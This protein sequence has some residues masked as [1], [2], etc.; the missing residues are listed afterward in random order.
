MKIISWNVNGIRACYKKGFAQYLESEA[1]D[2]LCLQESKA[3][4]ESLDDSILNIPNYHSYWH[5]AQRKGYS[6][7][8]IYSKEKPLNVT[9]GFGPEKFDSEGRVISAEY[10]DYIVFSVYFPNGQQGP[11]RLAYKLEFYNEF[12]NYCQALRET[13]KELI[14]CGDYNT[15][16]TEIDLANPK[17]NINTS[18]FM[19]IEREWLD[20]IIKLGYIDTFRLYNHHPDEYSWWS[21]RTAARDRNVGWR[22]DYVFIT[23]GLQEKLASGFIQQHVL[24]SDHCP[25]GIT[26]N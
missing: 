10:K 3:H 4:V 25:V 17:E 22:I 9:Y 13:G 6:G 1:P 19:P 23:P 16:H 18:G 2:V 5:S 20:H 11:E 24:G 26:L 14:I 12:F 21:Y 7:T 15:A 8:A